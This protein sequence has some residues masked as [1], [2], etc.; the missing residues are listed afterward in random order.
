MKYEGLAPRWLSNSLAIG[1]NTSY[2]TPYWLVLTYQELHTNMK[3]SLSPQAD[4]KRSTTGWAVGDGVGLP[5]I[6]QSFKS[7]QHLI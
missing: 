2:L 7:G 4:S 6:L 1:A 3:H 5:G